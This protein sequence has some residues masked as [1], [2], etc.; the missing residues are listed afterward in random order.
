VSDSADFDTDRVVYVI[1]LTNLFG[2]FG[3]ACP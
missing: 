3:Q 2:R 1:S